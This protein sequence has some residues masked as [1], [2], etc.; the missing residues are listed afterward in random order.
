MKRITADNSFFTWVT[1]NCTTVICAVVG[2]DDGETLEGMNVDGAVGKTVGLR[3]GKVVG[4][5]V[6]E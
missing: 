5:T 6:G 1:E 4:W 3:D 2:C